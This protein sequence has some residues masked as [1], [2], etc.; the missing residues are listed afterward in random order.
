MATQG[1][2]LKGLC[3]FFQ[4]SFQSTKLYQFLVVNGYEEVAAAVNRNVGDAEYF[5]NVERLRNRH[6]RR[7]AIVEEV[8][9]LSFGQPGQPPTHYFPAQFIGMLAQEQSC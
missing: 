8:R 5:F 6:T 3:D 2:K 7:I 9:F 4:D 1:E